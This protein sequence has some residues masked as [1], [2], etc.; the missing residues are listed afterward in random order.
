MTAG[1]YDIVVMNNWSGGS[2]DRVWVWVCAC[3]DRMHTRTLQGHFRS[4]F[5]VNG[6]DILQILS[7]V[8]LSAV[9]APYRLFSLVH[10]G[11]VHPVVGFFLI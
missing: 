6:N 8:L 3:A 11:Y 9:S 10:Q 7:D 2:P 5:V 1:T 4:S